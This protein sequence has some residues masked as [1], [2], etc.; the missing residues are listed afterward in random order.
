M[1]ANAVEVVDIVYHRSLSQ[2]YGYVDLQMWVYLMIAFVP[3]M[4][5]MKIF[6][7]NKALSIK[8]ML[9]WYILGSLFLCA[10]LMQF[11][12]MDKEHLH[13]TANNVL[14]DFII[15]SLLGGI[16]WARKGA[17][18]RQKQYAKEYNSRR[19]MELLGYVEQR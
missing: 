1:I 5:L 12:E 9:K 19:L 2:V 16:L 8:R 17:F 10:F 13:V 4:V 18:G 11:V 14:F 3:A 6:G 15:L 7:S